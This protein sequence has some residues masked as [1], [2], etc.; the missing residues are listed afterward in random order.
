MLLPSTRMPSGPSSPSIFTVTFLVILP[1]YLQTQDPEFAIQVALVWC[2]VEAAILGFGSLVGET[3]RRTI[4]R[5]VLLSCLAGLGLLLLAMNP[6][7]QSFEAPTV[8]FAVLALGPAFGGGEG[9]GRD[10]GE[11][12]GHGQG[13]VILRQNSA[14]TL[15]APSAL[16]QI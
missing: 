7:L 8:A 13:H 4:P 9:C 14:P 16:G 11:I 3:I 15:S 1:V 5:T 2:V 6:M 12:G 10:R